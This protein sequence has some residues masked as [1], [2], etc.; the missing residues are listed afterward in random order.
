[1]RFLILVFLFTGFCVA[2]CPK[3]SVNNS[4]GDGCFS[5]LEL[6]TTYARA[7]EYCESINSFAASVHNAFDNQILLDRARYV[8]GAQ[9]PSA[10][11]FWLGGYYDGSTIRW[12]DGSPADYT[13][14]MTGVNGSGNIVAQLQDGKWRV[15]AWNEQKPLAC[16][17][18]Y[19]SV[20]CDAP[21]DTEWFYAKQLKACYKVV[22]STNGMTW[23]E[24]DTACRSAGG[25]LTSITS[26]EEN[27]I[28]NE[29]ATTNMKLGKVEWQTWT[30]GVRTGPN[31]QDW[32]WIDGAP[33]NFTTWALGQPDDGK[34]IQ[35]CLQVYTSV[36][37]GEFKNDADY[38]TKWD[39]LQCDANSLNG[40]CKKVAKY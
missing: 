34:G 22:G 14:F 2:F 12:A 26:D 25:I 39:D 33:F 15:A 4:Q 24:A 10:D 13:N 35:N 21:C 7:E 37:S 3:N 17:G 18:K 30:G 27:R 11:A 16:V 40:V 38:L 6:A 29:I 23:N 19:E 1:M 8:L 5:V 36:F 31:P 32:R 9:L 20:Q 28:V